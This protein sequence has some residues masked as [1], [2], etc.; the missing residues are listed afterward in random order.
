MLFKPIFVFDPLF[1]WAR[2]K[3]EPVKIIENMNK[4]LDYEDEDEKIEAL[5]EEAT[6]VNNLGAM[7]IGWMAF[8]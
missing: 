3:T 2:K 7:Y 5:I 1:E 6:D 8:I 4:K